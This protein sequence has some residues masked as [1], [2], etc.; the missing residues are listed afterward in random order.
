MRT[1]YIPEIDLFLKLYEDMY[2]DEIVYEIEDT[3][4]EEQFKQLKDYFIETKN[5]DQYFRC[6][7]GELEVEVRFGVISHRR[8][9]DGI[10]VR[11]PLV[12]KK[13]DED[14][15]ESRYS[16]D[17]ES[18]IHSEV[19]ELRIINDKLLSILKEKNVISREELSEIK[20]VDYRDKLSKYFDYQT[21]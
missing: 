15:E 4:T 18:K 1:A 6:V 5:K 10:I 16:N 9:S 11:G 17:F 3:I 19:I 21:F 12:E 20:K 7:I 2:G 8:T 13:Y 14:R